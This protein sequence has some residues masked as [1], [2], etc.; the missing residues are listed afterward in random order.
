MGRGGREGVFKPCGKLFERD[1][2]IYMHVANASTAQ[3]CQEGTS[4]EGGP[5]VASQRTYVSS[6][7]TPDTDAH[8]HQLWVEM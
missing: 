8:L 4:V 2:L 1:A 5:D 3:R 6:L 7:A